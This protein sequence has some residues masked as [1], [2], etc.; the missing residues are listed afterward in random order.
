[1]QDQT[2]LVYLGRINGVHGVRGQVKIH[3][4]CRPREA[5]FNYTHFIAKRGSRPISELTLINGRPQGK[6]LVAKFQGFDDRDSAYTL[7]GLSLYIPRSELPEPEEDEFYWMDLIGLTAINKSGEVL[8][9]V[10]DLFETGA[11]DVIII[12]D[13]NNE[14]I[15]IPFV[16]PDY[17][18]EVDFDAQ[19]VTVD[20]LREWSKSE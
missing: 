20:W 8:G 13:D 2:A 9:T 12:R 19:Q 17:I 5:I 4:D 15:L 16:V 3:S 18:V 11:N 10:K 6:G 14:E 7:N 1:M